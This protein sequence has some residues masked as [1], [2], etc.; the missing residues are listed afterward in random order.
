MAFLASG[1]D[2]VLAAV[3]AQKALDAKAI[4]S[5]NAAI[6]NEKRSQAEESQQDAEW[7]A[8]VMAFETAFPTHDEQSKYIADF[9][10]RNPLFKSNPDA[11]RCYAISCFSSTKASGV[12][13][14]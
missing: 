3:K 2:Q 14:V 4:A 7:Q 5:Q 12:T 6:E 8:K 9:Q 10:K 1:I 13:H 11:L